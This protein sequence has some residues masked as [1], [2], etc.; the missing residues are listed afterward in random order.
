MSDNLYA[1]VEPIGPTTPANSVRNACT[2][3]KVG[4]SYMKGRGIVA[5]GLPLERK[6]GVESI[7][8]TNGDYATIAGASR[9]NRKQV[10]EWHKIAGASLASLDQSGF[11]WVL[12]NKVCAKNGL[13]VKGGPRK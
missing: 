12:V 6:N 8:I 1:E 7:L 3:V 10:A 9:L 5:S 13:K 2:H 11:V 4:I